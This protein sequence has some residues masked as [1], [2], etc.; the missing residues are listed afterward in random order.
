MS[1]GTTRVPAEMAAAAM[2][3]ERLIA[4]VGETVAES[5]PEPGRARVERLLELGLQVRTDEE[6]RTTELMV[7][8]ILVRWLSVVREQL[9]DEDDRVERVL[10]W[11]DGTL[12]HRYA[13][14]ARYTSAV[15]LDE[16]RAP[17]IMGYRKALRGDFLPSLVWLLA[18]VVATYGDGDVAWLGNLVGAPAPH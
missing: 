6:G 1:R 11:V 8:L 9:I 17:E 18:G 15:L 14:R 5:S 16:T 3:A 4:A 13:A 10:A 2:L 12:G 7:T